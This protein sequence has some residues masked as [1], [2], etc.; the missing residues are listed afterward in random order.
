[1][2]G[3][4][5]SSLIAR[6]INTLPLILCASPQYLQQ[7]GEPKTPQ[8]IAQHHCII[9]SNFRIGTQWPIV[10]P[11][12]KTASIKVNSRIAAS[13]PS[14]VKAIAEAGGG[15]GLV[16]R[17]IVEPAL[18]QGRLREVLPGYSTLEFGLFA[19]Y[20]HRRYLPKKVRSFIDFMVAEF[21][22]ESQDQR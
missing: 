17:F 19:L 6:R 9:D 22:E 8:D 15:I 7:Q 16:P 13:S 11:D 21:S 5:D 2:G 12:G 18:Q 1:V 3:V 14:A 20:P 10:S 4:D